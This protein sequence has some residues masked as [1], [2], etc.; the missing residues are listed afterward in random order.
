MT[1]T[2]M[3]PVLVDITPEQREGLAAMKAKTGKSRNELIRIAVDYML[4]EF[5]TASEPTSNQ[6]A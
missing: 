2:P 1:K 3:K 6:P 5:V 4:S